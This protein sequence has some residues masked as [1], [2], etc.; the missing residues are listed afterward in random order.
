M[1][2]V[3]TGITTTEVIEASVFVECCLLHARVLRDFFCRSEPRGDIQV[4]RGKTC[5]SPATRVR[6]VRL[7]RLRVRRVW[8]R[9]RRVAGLADSGIRWRG[10]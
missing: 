6:S 1:P 3:G 9:V 5:M 4:F 8:M 10:R 7:D 2:R